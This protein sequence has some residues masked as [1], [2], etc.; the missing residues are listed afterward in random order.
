MFDTYLQRLD[1]RAPLAPSLSFLQSLTSRH[2]AAHT[3]NNLSVLLREPMSLDLD[4]IY[5]KIVVRRAGGFCF[6]HNKLVMECLKAIGYE[7]RLVMARVLNNHVRDVPRTH[8]ITLVNLNGD[9]YLVDCGFGASVP[10]GPVQVNTSRIQNVRDK[11][12]QIMPV[13]ADE[14]DV[15]EYRNGE[16]FILYRFDSAC[17]SDADCTAG[18]HYSISHPDAVFVRNLVVS[19]NGDSRC[20]AFVN[21]TFSES[22]NGDTHT[23]VIISPRQLESVLSEKFSLNT[24]RAICELLFERHVLPHLSNKQR[25]QRTER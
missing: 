12:Y 9:T 8:R 7:T 22:A 20:L 11:Q 24:D 23:S 10:Q 1:L 21:H 14:Y 25:Q 5:H 19:L 17:Y 4:A 6:E 15:A 2:I 18:H 13:G 16:P 3:F